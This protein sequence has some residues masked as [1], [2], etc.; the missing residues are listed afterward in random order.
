[1][2][3]EGGSRKVGLMR[4]VSHL[5]DVKYFLAGADP[6]LL[7]DVGPGCQNGSRMQTAN[8]ILVQVC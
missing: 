8:I 3:G 4:T 5:S 2:I 6:R 1:M 7:L